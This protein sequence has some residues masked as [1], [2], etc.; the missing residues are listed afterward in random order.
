ML[1]FLIAFLISTTLSALLVRSRIRGI[2]WGTDFE[3]KPQK[4]HDGSPSRI[5]GVAIFIAMVACWV[6]FFFK[7]SQSELMYLMI[8]ASSL[9]VFFA[10]LWE[11][12]TKNIDFRIRF[13]LSLVSAA[14]LI[15]LLGIPAIRIDI[16]PIDALLLYF[17][18][19]F[20]FLCIAIS[21]LCH[22][23]NLIDGLNGL[24]SMLGILCLS[25]ILY[26]SIKVNDLT[27]IYLCVIG[28]GAILG[29]FL[30]NYPRGL[31]FLGDGGAYLI[32]FWIAS[33]S[34]LVIVRNP[35]VSPWF[36]LAV[37]TYP[38]F[39]TLFSIWRRSIHQNRHVMM[40]DGAHFHSLIYRRMM[41]WTNPNTEG[42]H[43]Y[44]SNAKTSPYLWLLSSIGLIPAVLFWNSTQA[45]MIA[46]VL[47]IVLYVYLYR[48]IVRFKTPSWMANRPPPE[49][50]SE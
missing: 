32:G 15:L 2:S 9:P 5:G 22:A 1:L 17:P 27:I 42:E 23:Y 26:V 28:I 29:F 39:E 3:I 21:G 24:A 34:I 33:A 43:H 40:P 37:N 4:A 6:L 50:D 8:L 46:N 47:F 13:L 18:V 20:L 31:I 36:A 41:R 35:S 19:S 30:W 7:D 25:A 38:V 14:L 10:G 12:I 44:L 45:L 11:D 48:R 49:I 16:A